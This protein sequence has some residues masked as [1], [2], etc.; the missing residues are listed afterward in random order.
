MTVS[1]KLKIALLVCSVGFLGLQATEQLLPP[2]SYGLISPAEARVGRPF[3]PV[4]AAGVARRSVRRCAAG[5]Y[6]C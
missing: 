5:I 2:S 4:S 1:R 6:Y 3:T